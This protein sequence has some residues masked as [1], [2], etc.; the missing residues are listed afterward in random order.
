MNSR[1]TELNEKKKYN[2]I[3][4]SNAHFPKLFYSKIEWLKNRRD[5]LQGNLK[6]QTA[7]IPEDLVK[8]RKKLLNKGSLE[9]MKVQSLMPHVI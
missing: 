6:L 1:S 7:A 9:G 3:L 4:N 8:K 5:E 2:A